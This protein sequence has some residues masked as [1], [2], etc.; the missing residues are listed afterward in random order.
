VVTH[1][2]QRRKLFKLS[3]LRSEDVLSVVSFITSDLINPGVFCIC[4][5]LFKYSFVE[6]YVEVVLS[7]S[8]IYLCFILG[9]I[10]LSAKC[11]V[12]LVYP[13]MGCDWLAFLVMYHTRHFDVGHHQNHR[14]NL[15]GESV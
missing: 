3:C 8:V 12:P 15:D 11:L 6:I 13:L 14:Q 7:L 2:A 4:N 10:F 1:A 9:Y 5:V